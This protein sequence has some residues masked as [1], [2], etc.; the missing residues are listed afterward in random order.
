M[1]EAQPTSVFSE[2]VVVKII[3]DVFDRNVGFSTYNFQESIS[4]NQKC[5]EEIVSELIKLDRPY[6]FT[7][8][9]S[10]FQIGNGSGLNVSTVSYWNKETDVMYTHR[11]EGRHMSAIVNV[12][13]VAY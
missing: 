3:S 6:K 4:W 7:V 13:A 12:F 8:S 5:V 2:E 10:L 1:P 11:W 9:A